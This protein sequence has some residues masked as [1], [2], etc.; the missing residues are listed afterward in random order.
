MLQALI[1]PFRSNAFKHIVKDLPDT[2]KILTFTILD[3][4]AKHLQKG[5]IR[6]K[7]YGEVIEVLEYLAQH[8]AILLEPV[9][10]TQVYKIGKQK[11][12]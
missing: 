3:S 12:D 1:F 5:G 8:D 4:V 7:T 6:C 2:P 10:E 9:A 11:R